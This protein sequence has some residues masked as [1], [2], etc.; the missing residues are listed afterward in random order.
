MKQHVSF[1]IP[2]GDLSKW[3]ASLGAE[4]VHPAPPVAHPGPQTD[5]PDSTGPQE[6]GILG[7]QV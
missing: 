3:L 1:K 4:Q 5:D 2:H 7:G 6:A